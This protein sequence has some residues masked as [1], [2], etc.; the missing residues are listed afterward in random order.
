M[1]HA[2]PDAGATVYI[3]DLGGLGGIVVPEDTLTPDGWPTTIRFVGP[4]ASLVVD[5]DADA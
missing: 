4:G 5:I 1:P 2:S 3:D